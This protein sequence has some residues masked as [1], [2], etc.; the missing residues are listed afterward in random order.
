MVP[1]DYI[2]G[3]HA[4]GTSTFTLVDSG[5]TDTLGKG[6]KRRIPVRL[7]YPVSKESI[8][9]AKKALALSER[10]AKAVMKSTYARRMPD[11]VL[12]PEHYDVPMMD[13][14]FPLIMLSHGYDSYVE[15]HTFLCCDIASHG[16]IVA[17]VGHANEAIFN[18][19]DDGSHDVFDKSITKKMYDKN[20]VSVM[21]AMSRTKKHKSAREALAAFDE[22]Q[23]KYSSYLRGRITEWAKDIR[24]AADT[25]KARYIDRIDLTH[26]I[27]ATGHSYGGCEAYYLCRYDDEFSCGINIDGA[28]FGE[29]DD[30]PMT[31]P[32]CQISC[33]ANLSFETRPFLGTEA[34]TYQVIFEDMQHIGFADAKFFCPLRSACGKL[35]NDTL[36]SNLAYTH[37]AFFDRYLKGM[38]IPFGREEPKVHYIKIH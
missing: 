31:K 3:D 34:D 2:T 20:V 10:K 22:F 13:K 38:D 17:S 7:Y 33:K 9:G 12:Y 28:L 11:E 26:G 1:S 15:A 8:T 5:R 25:I 23:M 24:F 32:F 37:Y 18:D 21:I 29:Y 36:H 14:R 16:Y 27:G 6:G 4:V 30:T 19:Y 35:D